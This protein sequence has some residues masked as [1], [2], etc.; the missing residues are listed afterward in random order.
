MLLTSG[1]E[2]SG[3][4]RVSITTAQDYA[5]EVRRLTHRELVISR[6]GRPVTATVSPPQVSI[7]DQGTADVEVDG[8]DYR[9]Y[10]VG[11]DR[12]PGRLDALSTPAAAI[13]SGSYG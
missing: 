13:N 1:S 9:A 7:E 10:L 11:L 12:A 6:A 3:V 8:T 5:A 2:P 4:L